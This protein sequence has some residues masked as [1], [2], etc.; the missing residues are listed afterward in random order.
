[1]SPRIAASR[2]ISRTGG[3]LALGVAVLVGACGGKPPVCPGPNC[4]TPAQNCTY[5]VSGDTNKSFD[6][7]GGS[8]T[9]AVN[10]TASSSGNTSAVCSWSVGQPN[11]S[12]VTVTEPT[13]AMA[14]T[15][16]VKFNVG[17]NNGGTRS[18]T[19]A[20]TGTNPSYS[21]TVT[22]NQNAAQCTF[23]LSGDTNKAFDSNGGTGK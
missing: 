1:M 2:V 19:F 9:V 12:F 15:G 4:P 23:E 11:N 14:A 22:V 7:P 6:P 3:V 18:A 10:V 20:I 21:S 8:G 16:S 5:A 13:S 17:S